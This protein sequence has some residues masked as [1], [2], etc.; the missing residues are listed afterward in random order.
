ME[1]GN[2]SLKNDNSSWIS[3]ES[4]TGGSIQSQPTRDSKYI[5]TLLVQDPP[6]SRMLFNTTFYIQKMKDSCLFFPIGLQR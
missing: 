3:G 5:L 4:K 2:I 1:V 6:L